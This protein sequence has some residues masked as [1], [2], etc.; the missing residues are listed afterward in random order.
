MAAFFWEGREAR[1]GV[2]VEMMRDVS[3]A[4]ISGGCGEGT[5][6]RGVG[7]KDFGCVDEKLHRSG[8]NARYDEAFPALSKAMALKDFEGVGHWS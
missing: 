1:T 6:E 4:G 3:G 5:F 7:A 8:S 2:A